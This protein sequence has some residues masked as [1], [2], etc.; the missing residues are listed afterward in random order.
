MNN[1]YMKKPPLGA[2]P[3]W[4]GATKRI[5]ELAKAIDRTATD[6]SDGDEYRIR[7]WA[8]EI[9]MQCGIL[10]DLPSE[11]RNRKRG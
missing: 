11:S 4:L 2:M 7:N 10:R 1:E 5:V 9:I 6:Y 3:A 8:Q